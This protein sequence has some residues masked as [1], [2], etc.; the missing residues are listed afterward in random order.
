MAKKDNL[1]Q[2]IASMSPAE[3][4]QF[5]LACSVVPGDK[6][7]LKLFDALEAE[8][9]YNGT[10]LCRQ[11]G[12]TAKQLADDKHYLNRVLLGNLRSNVPL[13]TE[14]DILYNDFEDAR[15]LVRR[16]LYTYAAELAEDTL[17][18]ARNCEHFDLMY[19]LLTLLHRCYSN[20]QD[21]SRVHAIGEELRLLAVQSAERNEMRWITG[22][23]TDLQLKLHGA[24]QGFEKLMQHPLM[25]KQPGELN[26]AL[27]RAEWFETTYRYY[28]YKGDGKAIY[29]AT[30]R[31]WEYYKTDKATKQRF[32]TI[33]ILTCTR[34]INAE[35]NVGNFTRMQKLAEQLKLEIKGPFIKLNKAQQQYYTD[36]T[37]CMLLLALYG[38]HQNEKLLETAAKMAYAR[39]PVY[40]CM[41]LFYQAAALINLQRPALAI[42]KLEE[43][44]KLGNDVRP[45][46]R[47]AVRTMIIIAQYDLGN[48]QIL[49]HLVQ[50]T[51]LWLKR[52]GVLDKEYELL[53]SLLA[54]IAKPND[55]T[56]HKLAWQNLL[57]AINSNKLPFICKTIHLKKWVVGHAV[58][59]K[60]LSSAIRQ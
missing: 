14:N 36:Y 18:R 9:T 29:D 24:K 34:M 31:E 23:A 27:A 22:M 1:L 30:V 41:Y 55:A 54:A 35:Y 57:K 25:K 45:D 7:Y 52:N 8:T 20:Q 28:Y 43:L 51:K 40:Q 33:Y 60:V 13:E 37:D 39:K 56:K 6:R 48:Y 42:D 11:L 46:L 50:S 4:R 53:F 3:K 5:K 2:L 44:L 49:P 26:S 58:K 17:K 12:L 38:L 19:G 10:A 59:K 21:Y 15:H 16:G 47:G 32:P